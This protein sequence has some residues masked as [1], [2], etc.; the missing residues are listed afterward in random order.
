MLA[1]ARVEEME[2]RP[3]S[4]R[5]TIREVIAHLADWEEI[6]LKRMT[7]TKTEHEPLLASI[8]VGQLAI[9]HDYTR[10]DVVEQLRLF[11]VRREALMGFLKGLARTEWTRIAVRPDIGRL[12]M[13]NLAV[14]V[15]LHDTYHV[16]QVAEWRERFVG[17]DAGR[18]G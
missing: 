1:G 11:S 12:T 6:W 14:L 15:T 17:R 5:F 7:L 13:E 4:D 8:D 9:D 3:D 10:R 18:N 16:R 2:Y